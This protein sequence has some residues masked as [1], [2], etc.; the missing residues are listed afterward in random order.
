MTN[1][2]RIIDLQLI[3]KIEIVESEIDDIVEMINPL[4]GAEPRMSRSVDGEMLGQ[5]VQERSPNHRATRPMQEEERRA[6]PTPL[7]RGGKFP[8]PDRHPHLLHTT[9]SLI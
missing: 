4:A 1:N 7:H 5:L 8:V 2:V 9:I 3:K 6:T